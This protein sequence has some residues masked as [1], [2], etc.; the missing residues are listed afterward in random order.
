MK[1]IGNPLHIYSEDPYSVLKL[2]D[3]KWFGTKIQS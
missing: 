1:Q 2:E 3:I